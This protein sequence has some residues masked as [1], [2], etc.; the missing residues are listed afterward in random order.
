MHI[1]ICSLMS[2]VVGKLKTLS[3]T[4]FNGN[5]TEAVRDYSVDVRATDWGFRRVGGGASRRNL[6]SSLLITSRSP[7]HGSQVC[8]DGSSSR[9]SRSSLSDLSKCENTILPIASYYCSRFFSAFLFPFHSQLFT[10]TWPGTGCL[11]VLHAQTRQAFR[12]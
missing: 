3:R 12:V 8:H 6:S 7:G 1:K 9:Q 5:S 10:W 2:M 4:R 11:N